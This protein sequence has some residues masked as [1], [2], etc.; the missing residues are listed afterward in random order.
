MKLL[1]GEE[2]CFFEKPLEANKVYT[3][4]EK[5]ADF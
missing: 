2:A 5:F 4:Q 1:H 3:I